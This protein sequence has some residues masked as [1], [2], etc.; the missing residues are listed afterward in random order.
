MSALIQTATESE[1]PS[2]AFGYQTVVP[3]IELLAVR[4]FSNNRQHF[5]PL[6]KFGIKTLRT[7]SKR[8][9]KDRGALYENFG[10]RFRKE[11]FLQ[12]QVFSPKPYQP[13]MIPFP[14]F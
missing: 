8:E 6:S 13:S 9:I 2:T 11:T 5:S 4:H 14:L 1:M 12:C 3:S 7:R 10:S